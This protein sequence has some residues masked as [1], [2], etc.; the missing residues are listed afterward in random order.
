VCRR[1]REYELRRLGP[2]IDYLEGRAARRR[3]ALAV[4]GQRRTAKDAEL[5]A[6]EV[7]I[8]RATSR[9]RALLEDDESDGA[10]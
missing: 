5:D 8:D 6:V 7:E 9:L 1:E 10:R 4:R 3:I 2:L